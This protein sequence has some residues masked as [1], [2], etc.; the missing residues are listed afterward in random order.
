MASKLAG[1]RSA[2]RNADL[3]KLLVA[4]L[5]SNTCS[6][7]YTVALAAFAY[8]ETHSAGWVAAASL[9]RFIPALVFSAYGGVVAE[10]FERVRVMVT[11]DLVAMCM[12]AGLVVVAVAH[13]P[14]GV[15]IALAA[16]CATA[17]TVYPPAVAA[18]VPQIAGE[19]ELVAAN[20]LQGSIDELVVVLGPALG[21]LLLVAGSAPLAF[22]V[23]T[24]SFGISALM[25]SRLRVR[26]TT[27]DVTEGGAA[28][29]LRQMLAGL[30]AILHSQVVAVL[31]LFSVA[32]SFVYGV[33]TVLFV[34][35][36]KLQLGTGAQGYG[37]LLAG[38]GLGGLLV[39][40]WI[41]RVAGSPRLGA[42]IM[43][44][45]IVYCLPTS[46]LI[47]VHS[48]GVAFVIEIVRGAG[49][50]VVD[51]LA[52]TA[53][54][55]A[56]SEDM[57]ARVFGVFFALVLAAISLGALVTPP[58]LGVISLHGALLV[59]GAGASAVSLLAFPW[60][61]RI[62]ARG[63]VDRETAAS[64]MS[65]IEGADIFHAASR[66]ALE[67]LARNAVEEAVPAGAVIVREGDPANAFFLIGEGTVQVS[68]RGEG[69]E[70]RPIRTLSRGEYFGEIGLLGRMPRTATV[71]TTTPCSL[72]RI[73]GDAFVAALTESPPSGLLLERAMARL[74]VTHPGRD[75]LLS[76]GPPPA[77]GK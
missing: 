61:R 15:A 65:L 67:R 18:T 4:L 40:A 53:L 72:L 75:A 27:S 1:Y 44:G 14:V 38:C 62:D 28:G 51:V 76:A 48:P 49:T 13:A 19:R 34:P 43:G 31:V 42:W 36:S 71:R 8:Q 74:T 7:S 37:Y 52:V 22:A 21:A 25:V 12:Q 73:S 32:A 20:A 69:A 70:E 45:L 11:S 66:M 23:N 10:R 54:Q 77:T 46:A 56:V 35:I 59:F 30:E 33:D 2:L 26:S 3:R 29:P 57:L 64:R 39:A 55:R 58:L 63:L 60:I 41:D 17:Q 50:I 47:F 68:S 9:G 5:V 6:W 24:V 16:A